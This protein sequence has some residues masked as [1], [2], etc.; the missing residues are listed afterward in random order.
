MS[1]LHKNLQA[2]NFTLKL[3]IE[4]TN[5]KLICKFEVKSNLNIWLSKTKFYKQKVFQTKNTTKIKPKNSKIWA[6]YIFKDQSLLIIK[7]SQHSVIC[8]HN[9][10]TNDI[11]KENNGQLIAFKRCRSLSLQYESE[12][13][14]KDDFKY[15]LYCKQKDEKT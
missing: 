3:F 7:N 1:L 4:D 2:N 12:E 10:K 14:I 15:N 9:Q 11:F 5:S 8:L 6:E 13:L